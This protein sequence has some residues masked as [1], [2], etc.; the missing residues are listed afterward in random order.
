MSDVPGPPPAPPPGP[1]PPG[2]PPPGPPWGPPPWGTD[3][4]QAPGPP[5]YHQ[6]ARERVQ[7]PAMGLIVV[8]L[9][10]LLVGLFSAGYALFTLVTPAQQLYDQQVRLTE[11]PGMPPLYA[12]AMRQQLAK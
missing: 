3:P 12:D 8:G 6:A 9:L 11:Q 10:N 4:W 5:D 2:G 1:T 7:L